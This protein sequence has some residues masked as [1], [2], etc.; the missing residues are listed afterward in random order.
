MADTISKTTRISTQQSISAHNPEYDQAF[1][2]WVKCRDV[3]KV[4]NIKDKGV[5]YLPKLDGQDDNAYEAY[6]DRACPYPA[7][8]RT[9]NGMSGMVFM[10]D[11]VIDGLP[12]KLNYIKDDVT[13]TG[14]PLIGLSKSAFY[15]TMG[16]G[17]VGLLTDHTEKNAPEQR[18]YIT[19]YQA[20]QIINW[21]QER[22]FGK[23]TTILVVLS[24]WY[25]DVDPADPFV[26][27]YGEQYRVLE[28]VM[29]DENGNPVS[30]PRYRHRLY[31]VELED[32]PAHPGEKKAVF[33]LH[34]EIWP[35]RNGKPLD[36]IPFVVIGSEAVG[37]DLQ[38]S[39]VEDMADVVLSHYRNS[40]DLENGRHWCGIPQP[41]LAG[42]PEKDEYKIGGNEIWISSN[43]QATAGM[44][45]FTGQGLTPL[46]NAMKEKEDKLAILGMR[47]LESQKKTA[48]VAET[49]RIRMLA[50]VSTLQSVVRTIS[51]GLTVAV[52]WAIW[53]AS[54]AGQE[55]TVILNL[56]YDE[57]L[58]TSQDLLALTTL[59]QNDG[60]SHL[61][62]YENLQS[63]EITREGVTFE[64][65][66]EQIQTEKEERENLN[67][68][69]NPQLFD[70]NG[71]P[72]APPMP[73]VDPNNPD[74]NPP[75]AEGQPVDGN[76]GA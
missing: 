21:R 12:E 27:N 60:I 5:E 57:S 63:G 13:F 30:T 20:E 10:K 45:E 14:I 42:F 9:I 22:Q 49:L 72:I 44:L 37:W 48:E 70:E 32:D 38:D 8:R 28:L 18:P 33:Y 56:D 53:W 6:K 47:L 7:V 35:D 67:R 64:E 2:T 39:P 41:Y 19:M 50:D 24:E 52:N 69:M 46:E 55:A 65:E 68:K 1:L 15:E 62:L 4:K 3:L 11:L 25:N 74:G 23:M 76:Q 61:T 26:I 51:Q 59:W 36:F 31:R 40:A 73:V 75:P 43:A 66:L 54:A 34:Q 58:L 29:E 17:R 16:L 71:N